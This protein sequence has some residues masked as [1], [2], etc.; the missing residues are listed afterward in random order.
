[1]VYEIY[2]EDTIKEYNII[3]KC[4]NSKIS[5]TYLR[6]GPP[7]KEKNHS[8]KFKAKNPNYFIKDGYLW[9]EE[10]RKYTDFLI[11]LKDFIINRIPESLN[12]INISE[13]INSK[14][15]SAKKAI[16]VLKDMVLP[17]I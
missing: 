17:Y 15:S 12:L 9:V 11:F 14:T 2:F 13:A 6:K 1:M 7:V 4:Q 10:K 8:E 5:A 16:T 3:I